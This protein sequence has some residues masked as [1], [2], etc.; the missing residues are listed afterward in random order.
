MLRA[1]RI[2]RALGRQLASLLRA[3]R[4]DPGLASRR[5]EE[6]ESLADA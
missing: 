6:S 3:P 4:L 1:A 2:G 5:K